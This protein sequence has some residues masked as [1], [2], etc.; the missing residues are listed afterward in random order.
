[1]TSLAGV[2]AES[3]A[4]FNELQGRTFVLHSRAALLLLVA[5]TFLAI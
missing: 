4:D 1:V 2:A 3:K 5:A